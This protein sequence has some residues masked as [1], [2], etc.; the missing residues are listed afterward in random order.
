M[1]VKDV[2]RLY[3][4]NGEWYIFVEVEEKH[5]EIKRLGPGV[6]K[7][8][9][10]DILSA[11]GRRYKLSEFRDILLSGDAHEVVDCH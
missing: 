10:K 6:I 11:D 3:E 1:D 8:A 2:F 7:D 9:D 5:G 4:S